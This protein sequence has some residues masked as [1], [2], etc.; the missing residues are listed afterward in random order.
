MNNALP[1]DSIDPPFYYGKD[2]PVPMKKWVRPGGWILVALLLYGGITTKFKVALV[3][4]AMYVITLLT[5]KTIAVTSRGLETF[6][7]MRITTQ[8][9]FWAWED[10]YSITYEFDYQHSG[11]VALYFTCGDRTRRL[12]FNKKEK[13]AI[14]ALGKEKN[15]SLVIYDAADTKRKAEELKKRRR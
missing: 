2:R 13:D 8:Y 1:W 5:K 3:F 12:F 9:D 14:I 15:P 4:A 11:V 10:M 7:Q 6:Y